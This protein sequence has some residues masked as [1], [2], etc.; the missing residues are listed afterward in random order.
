MISFVLSVFFNTLA[1]V[2]ASRVMDVGL[3]FFPAFLVVGSSLLAGDLLQGSDK[4]VHTSGIVISAVITF[5]GL[6]FFTGES[7]WT[8]FKLMIVSILLFAA[9]ALALAR[10][11]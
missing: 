1:L 9:I 8:V 4:N 10:L 3:R 7:S 2:L 11:F 5:V 6:K